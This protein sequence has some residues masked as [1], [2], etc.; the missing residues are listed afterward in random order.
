M[1]AYAQDS[2][3]AAGGGMQDQGMGG[4]GEGPMGPGMDPGISIGITL[5]FSLLL[6]YPFWRIYRRAGLN[7]WYSLLV[8][9]P[10]VGLPAAAAILA[11]QKWPNGESKRAGKG[12]F[13]PKSS[14]GGEG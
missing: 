11:F 9:L 6:I 8:V 2:S 5:L 4:P 14:N 1:D 3:G 12:V 7:P 13:A 10:Y